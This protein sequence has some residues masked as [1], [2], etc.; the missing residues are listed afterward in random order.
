M[1]ALIKD[2]RYGLRRLVESPGFSLVAVL[3]LALGIGAN[4][5]LF[6]L[7]NGVLWTH[8]PV[9]KDSN[10]LVW[11][12]GGARNGPQGLSTSYPD[13]LDYR[14]QSGSFS[15]IAAFSGITLSVKSGGEP[16]MVPGMIV[17]G[18]YFSVL[19][20]DAADGRMFDQDDDRE[21]GANPVAVI[22][23]GLW[24]SRF[25]SD[26][27]LVGKPITLNGTSFTVVGVAPQGFVG[28]DVASQPAIWAPMMMY[29]QLNLE[30]AAEA[31]KRGRDILHQRDDRWL[32][33]VARLR[34]G[35]A[36][37]QAQA[38]LTTIADRIS[39][40][41]PIT[42]KDATVAVSEV[43]GGIDPRDRSN[44]LPVAALLTA[45]LLLVL[46]IVCTNLTSFLL[47][48]SSTRMKEIGIRLALGATR[49]Q[50]I[51]Q[52]LAESLILAFVGG[53]LGLL[54]NYWMSNLLSV[55]APIRLNVNP[56]LRVLMFALALSLA[57]ALVFGLVPA[58]QAS[59]PDMV[60][61]LK[62]EGV[63]RGKNSASRVR[64][65]FV[66]GQFTM[67]L[68]LLI[69]A[70]FF[71]KSLL[72]ARTMDL[73]F[74]AR[75][76]L[77]V[78]LDLGLHNYQEARG[79]VFYRQVLERAQAVPGVKSATLTGFIPLDQTAYGQAGVTI[80]GRESRPEDGPEVAGYN[81]VGD[82]YFQVMGI[83]LVRGRQ[84]SGKDA[85]GATPAVII[86]QAMAERYWPSSD[87]LGKRVSVTGKKGP[88]LEVV[89]IVKTGKYR[90]LGEPP[91]PYL[92]KPLSQEYASKMVLVVRSQ[93]EPRALTSPVRSMLSSMDDNL[94][95]SQI[96]SLAQQVDLSL[97]PAR[98]GA[99]CLGGFGLLALILAA[100][101]IYGVASYM[102]TQSSREIGIRMVLGAQRKDIIKLV[103]R[104]GMVIVVIGISVGLI[105]SVGMARIISSFLYGV[106]AVDIASFVGIPLLLAAVALL[107]TFTPAMKASGLDP[108]L[109]IRRDWL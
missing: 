108:Q 71:I 82:D 96:T 104:E 60:P 74:E 38:E 10:R 33:I 54:L 32:N 50:L 61:A 7:L 1:N 13:Y 68:V 92:Y 76:A 105:I 22:S 80:E 106:S 20:V 25:G 55:S 109:A 103:I 3:S 77:L 83:P 26:R 17:S 79:K 2:I 5:G 72:N 53:G 98:T 16:Q 95:V 24:Q 12:F 99:M 86:N 57:T 67:S 89:G 52:L 35:A 78:P 43:A 73:G 59:K 97:M 11:I 63:L 75:D 29:G 102:V 40:A 85:E 27:S 44:L 88:Y 58:L 51:R 64:K 81:T 23:Y 101:G 8:L 69:T 4:T 18:N 42:N 9:I 66:I 6:S 34:E 107:A 56:D 48:R 30:A 90:S 47:A 15:G 93:G 28:L 39:Q 37:G 84:F 70:S 46:L 41:N 14:D 87:A 65:L 21:P 62:N 36:P 91:L 19:G 49:L 94:P 45:V 31:K 100:I